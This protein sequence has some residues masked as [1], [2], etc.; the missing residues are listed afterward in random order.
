MKFNLN[1][2]DVLGT[3]IDQLIDNIARPVTWDSK[4]CLGEEYWD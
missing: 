1:V 2:A 3:L 4:D